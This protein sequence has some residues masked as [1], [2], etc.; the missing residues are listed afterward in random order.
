MCKIKYSPY[1]HFPRKW[2]SSII[3]ILHR[4]WIPDPGFAIGSAEASQVEND[5]IEQ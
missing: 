1:F 5:N 3:P 2:E 4:D